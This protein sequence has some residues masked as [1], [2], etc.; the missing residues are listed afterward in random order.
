MPASETPLVLGV[1]HHGSHSSSSAGFIAAL[2][3]DLA[4]V[5]AGW[6][7]RYGHPHPEVVARYRDAGAEVV[8]TAEQGALTIDFPADAKPRAT[9]E[10]ERRRRYWRESGASPSH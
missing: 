9:A 5:S 6:R 1:P 3:P 8:N 10:R 2:H 4:I 7:S